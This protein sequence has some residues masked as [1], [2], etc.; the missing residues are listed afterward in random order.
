VVDLNCT[1]PNVSIW[2]EVIS[3]Y[4]VDAV[5]DKIVLQLWAGQPV[6]SATMDHWYPIPRH[7]TVGTVYFSGELTPG[8]VERNRQEM[9]KRGPRGRYMVQGT[10]YF[11]SE[12]GPFEVQL[13]RLEREVPP[14]D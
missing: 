6:L 8:A 12:S 14:T 4:A 3:H 13:I 10:A 11:S 2:F 5:L 1:V 9:A 7:S